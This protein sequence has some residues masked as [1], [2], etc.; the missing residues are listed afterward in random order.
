MFQYNVYFGL[1]FN[2]TYLQPVN[3]KLP[4]HIFTESQTSKLV[5]EHKSYI[6]KYVYLLKTLGNTRIY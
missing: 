1:Q 5:K 3:I 6:S 4:F 2:I